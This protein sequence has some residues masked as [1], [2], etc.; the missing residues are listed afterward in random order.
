MAPNEPMCAIEGLAAVFGF[1]Q[2]GAYDG[3]DG[4]YLM[5]R[6]LP[7]QDQRSMTETHEALHHDLQ[8]SSGWGL[9]SSGVQVLARRGFRP[10]AFRELFLQLV[11]H[12]RNTHETFATTFSAMTGD[13]EQ[14]RR[15]LAGNHEYLAYLDRGLNLVDMADG[16]PWQFH[17]A[18]IASVLRVCM[19]PAAMLS[20]LQQGFGTLRRP[21]SSGSG[22]PLTSGSTRMNGPAVRRPGDRCSTG[23]SPSFPTVAATRRTQDA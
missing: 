5:I 3:T 12:A 11:E 4:W 2:L 16:V 7:G 22:T 15:L 1:D 23:W 17:S 18:A 19:R 14:A 10:H 6:N 13:V 21:M 8:W 20:L 9:L